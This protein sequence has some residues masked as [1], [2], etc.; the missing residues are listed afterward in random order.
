MQNKH[1]IDIQKELDDSQYAIKKDTKKTI[2]ALLAFL[3]ACTIAFIVFD[4]YTSY[5]NASK[6]IKE[7][8]ITLQ[9]EIIK[10]RVNNV[11]YMIDGSIQE[12]ESSIKKRVFERTQQ[13]YNIAAA[14]Y[15]KY[16]GKE[17]ETSIQERIKDALRPLRWNNGR[18]Y[19]WIV[20]SNNIGILRPNIPE[21]EGQT[22]KNFKDKEGNYVVRNQTATAIKK[23]EGFND[24]YFT[25]YGKPQNEV[26]PQISFVKNFG[27][28]GWYFGSAEF[29]D[30]Y[31]ELLKDELL[32]RVSNIRYGKS[33]IFINDMNGNALLSNGKLLEEPKNILELTDKNGVKVVQKEIAIAKNSAEGGFLEYAWHEASL[34]KDVEKIAFIRQI[35]PLNWMIGSS[36]PLDEINNQLDGLYAD[37]KKT[38]IFN[39]L[40]VALFFAVVFSI[41]FYGI[42]LYNRRLDAIA[43][44]TKEEL[45]GSYKQ[46]DALNQNLQNMV[47]EEVA[48]NREKDMLL[49]KQSRQATMG[50]MI[51]NIAHQ[52]RQPLNALGLT[53]QDLK[54]AWQYGEVN[55][56][57]IEEAV[58][59]SMAQ[60]R[61]MSKTID[62]FR[63]F[64]KPDKEKQT[65]NLNNLTTK[66]VEFL[67]ASMKSSEIQIFVLKDEQY[68]DIEAFGYEN[69]L[70]QVIINI[71]NNAKD[72]FV[73]RAIK[74]R[75]ITISTKKDSEFSKLIIKDNAGGVDEKIIENIFDPYF[76]TK[77]QGKGTGIG[78]YMSKEII[79]KNMN[80]ALRVYNDADGAIFEICLPSKKPDATPSDKAL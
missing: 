25:K 29:V 11:T 8:F 31:R 10:T 17:P 46:L 79:E 41:A 52:W 71:L 44:R 65:F 69:E 19:I 50:E 40:T 32:K 16:N 33:Y 38:V 72:E 22:L 68:G 5:A 43:K 76:T 60:I 63:N 56:T 55:A 48:K 47:T 59:N 45:L 4:S 12:S 15:Q 73:S 74:E 39:I 53:V 20:D 58:N 61:Y 66:A 18:S 23:G 78:L 28:Y 37:F 24:D 9:K 36:I 75:K 57:Y 54:I 62:D 70:I 49:I 77:E 2:L 34:N 6:K 35:K 30:D 80:G 51:S 27:H 1:L 21:F 3:M 7:N 64:F 14:I 42:E 13:G 26:Y 67:S